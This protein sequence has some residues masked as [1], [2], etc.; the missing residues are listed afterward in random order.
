MSVECCSAALG[1][2]KAALRWPNL[3]TECLQWVGHR[4][5][6][7]SAIGSFNLQVS[8]PAVR[9]LTLLS[10]ADP[11]A[12]YNALNRPPGSRRSRP[13]RNTY[14]RARRLLCTQFR[15]TPRSVWLRNLTPNPIDTV[16]PAGDLAH[17]EAVV[18]LVARALGW[19]VGPLRAHE[20]SAPPYLLLREH[21]AGRG[22]SPLD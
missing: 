16:A 8:F 2:Q 5:P 3:S 18:E 13:L 10:L 14:K 6:R 9:S 22:Q 21:G 11:I 17:L 19:L 12:T 20:P 7:T 15:G 1:L 4:R